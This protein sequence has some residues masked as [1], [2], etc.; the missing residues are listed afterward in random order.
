[1]FYGSGTFGAFSGD[2]NNERRERQAR[3][4]APRRPDTRGAPA[5]HAG[6][7][8][9]PARGSDVSIFMKAARRSSPGGTGRRGPVA[10]GCAT[11]RV[12]WRATNPL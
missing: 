9:A 6:L 12:T 1:M 11:R 4:E 2:A 7:R 3:R 10:R 8:D 5:T